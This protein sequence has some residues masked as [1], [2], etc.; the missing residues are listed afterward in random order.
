[1]FQRQSLFC[2]VLGCQCSFLIG[3]RF[4]REQRSVASVVDT[5][6]LLDQAAGIYP[7]LIVCSSCSRQACCWTCS[8]TE[9]LTVDSVLSLR[10]PQGESLIAGGGKESFRVLLA[11]PQRPFVV[12]VTTRRSVFHLNGEIPSWKGG[13]ECVLRGG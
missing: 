9:L 3:T 10:S 6:L 12:V 8:S 4:C 7:N 2:F 11:S 13:D 5:V 1:M